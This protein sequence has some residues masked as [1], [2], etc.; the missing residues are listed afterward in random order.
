[1]TLTGV[2]IVRRQ[3]QWGPED[4][5]RERVPYEESDGDYK[6]MRPMDGVGLKLPRCDKYLHIL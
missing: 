3:L 5:R 2:A 4:V 1:M 6:K